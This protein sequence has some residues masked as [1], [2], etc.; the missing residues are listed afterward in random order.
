MAENNA[1]NLVLNTDYLTVQDEK[2]LQAKK[3][4]EKIS[5]TEG[6][7]LAV[8]QEQI[9]PSILR[10][11]NHQELNP[12]YDFKFT[13][14]QFK[15]ISQGINPDYWDNFADASSEA[16]AYQIREKLLQAQDANQKLET[17]GWK[18]TGLRVAAALTD[19][20]AL[21]ADG[22]TF[23][24]ARPFIYANK[25]SR[26]SKYIKSGLVGAGQ[27]GL[28]SA[29]VL[30]ADPTRDL[31][32]LGYIMAAGGAITAGLTRFL[33]PKHPDILEFE[34]K[35]QKFANAI[36]RTTL[37]NDGFK[38]TPQGE[39]YF[40]AKQEISLN[41]N[42]NE[43]D[44]LYKDQLKNVPVNQLKYSPQELDIIKSIKEGFGDD[45]LLN[46]FFDRIDQTPGTAN[47]LKVRLDK[48]FVLRRS[49]NPLMRSASEKIAEDPVGNIDKSTSILTADLHKNNYAATKMTQFYKEYEPAFR[50]FLKE[51][52]RSTN[53]IKY[54][55]N[56]RLEFARLVANATRGEGTELKSIQRG[57]EAS[58]KLFK[59]F[60]DDGKK[61]NVK[62]MEDI[63]DNQNYF[64]RHHSIAK[65]QD[66][67]EKIGQQNVVKFLSNSLR[68]G[69]DNLTEES[70]LK[71][72]NNIFKIVT[73]SK[74]RDGL[75]VNRLLKSTDEN[76]LKNL[77]KD[78]TDLGETEIN[79]LVKAL[80]KDRKPSLPSR[81]RRRASFDE[82][83]E[84][85]INGFRVKFSD[86]LNN[87]T[88][89]VVGGYIQQL[90]GH[91]ALARIGIKSKEDFNKILNRIIDGYNLPEVS[92]KYKGVIGEQK[93]KFELD[94]LETIYKNIL[95]IPTEA[96]ITGAYATVTRNIRKY[97]Y[98]N[99]F[100]Q[101]GFAGIPELG[102]VIG[103]AGIKS[104]IK[105][106][107]EFKSIVSRAKTGKLK[108]EF[109]DEIETLVSGTGS[110]R[111]VDS[112]INRTDDFAGVTTSVGKIEKTL[113][114][115]SRI[116]SD[117]SGF[118][119]VD[120][121]SRRLATISSFDKLARHAFGD[122]KLTASDIARYKNIGFTDADLQAV[123]KNI[124]EK[125]S[126][127]EGGLT[128]RKIRRLNV[129]QWEDQDLVNRM[130]LYMSRHLKRVIQEAN[131]GEMVAIG[132]DSSTGKLLLQFRN[133]MLNAYGKQLIHGIHMK[134]FTAF[135]SAMS[136]AFIASLVYVAQTYVQSIGKGKQ[137]KEDF[138]DKQLQPLA[139]GRAA[140]QRST[141]STIF[142]TLVDTGAYLTGFDPLFSYRTTGL[143]ANII[144]GNPTYT[145]FSNTGTA[146]RNTGKAIFDDQYDFS[147]SDANKWLRILPYQN[148]LGIKNVMQ[149]LIDGSD[150]PEKS[151]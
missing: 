89:S 80:V 35:S 147:K 124:R 149:Y 92:S 23:G 38:I 116:T 60:L 130:S 137:Q 57:A 81:L 110:N 119:I 61:Y 1:L 150:L 42:I 26:A 62:G 121:L 79:D 74:L 103:N 96:D 20:T 97:N 148:M 100:N 143:D 19:P 86:L 142:P 55:Y 44:E 28:V 127:V 69:S 85:V 104:F 65:Y 68:K 105:Y 95:G 88:E 14:D 8:Q 58:K 75:A 22:V 37:E 29:P 138:L 59:N 123:L 101:V 51:T 11:A 107:P 144:T 21:I 24:V 9:L 43:V 49:E 39:K 4:S 117:F 32:E 25:A 136:S 71:I 54:N 63:I 45:E 84:E 18:G 56:D 141:Y 132:A 78:Y 112:V 126:F 27:A 146:V 76:D 41:K 139:I 34:A 16:Q 66:I 133:F 15:E 115:A 111:L 33:A 94:T 114:I 106:I 122:L 3:E 48:S 125:S 131:Y 77:I 73:R 2:A 70:S 50:D 99:I 151:K 52:G 6:I 67:Q 30:A 47:P 83:H 31:D 64:P 10:A 102:N 40:G 53:F 87:N 91:I 128:G 82:S 36:E 5:L 98:A 134:D 120:T 109:L 72:A 12:D 90:S 7:S 108:N 13:E 145:L 93:K 135:S 140:F 46:S 118:H 17:L 113:D 129:D